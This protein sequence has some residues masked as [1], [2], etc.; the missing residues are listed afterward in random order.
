MRSKRS[1]ALALGLAAAVLA[2]LV[3]SSVGTASRAALTKAA[4]VT[5]TAGLNDRSFNHLANL[6]LQKAKKDLKVQGRAYVSKTSQDYLPNFVAVGN[7][8]GSGY[9]GPKYAPLIVRDLA[10]GLPDLA[11][12]AGV[13]DIDDRAS[14]VE[15][16]DQAFLTDYAAAAKK[17]HLTGFQ[18]ALLGS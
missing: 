17:A 5:D 15:E 12:A 2:A 7:G 4:I 10:R 18:R 16:L 11:P 6:G 14:L 9:L 3:A 8:L 1:A 13:S